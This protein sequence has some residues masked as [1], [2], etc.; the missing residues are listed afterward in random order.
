MTNTGIS[1]IDKAADVG[2]YVIIPCCFE[3]I[4]MFRLLLHDADM[5]YGPYFWLL[6]DAMHDPRILLDITEDPAKKYRILRLLPGRFHLMQLG[7]YPWTGTPERIRKRN[8]EE[9]N[10]LGREFAPYTTHLII[11]A[12]LCAYFVYRRRARR[13]LQKT[14]PTKRGSQTKSRRKR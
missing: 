7:V 6:R 9:W 10:A 11:I 3:L 4:R 12:A 8:I 13:S 1:A 14:D 2:V 5:A